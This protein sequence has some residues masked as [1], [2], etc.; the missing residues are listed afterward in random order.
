VLVIL[1]PYP[2]PGAMAMSAHPCGECLVQPAEGL[3][4][5]PISGCAEAQR[6]GGVATYRFP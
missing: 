2:G 5:R 4:P 3:E 6:T 1:Q